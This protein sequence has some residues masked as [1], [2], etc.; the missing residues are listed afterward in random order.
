MADKIDEA[1][2]AIKSLEGRVSA[3]ETAMKNKKEMKPEHEAAIKMALK[4]AAEATAMSKELASKAILETRFK[5]LETQVHQ[6]MAMADA[7]GKT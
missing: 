6:A 3:L 2:K 4:Q 7:L 1:L 5:L